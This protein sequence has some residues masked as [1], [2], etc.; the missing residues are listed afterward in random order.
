MYFGM[1]RISA[2]I[3]CI[4]ISTAGCEQKA[5]KDTPEPIKLQ[6]VRV[7]YIPIAECAHLYVG[8]DRGYFRDEGIDIELFP[9]RGGALI[10]PAVAKGDLDIGFSNVVSLVLQNERLRAESPNRLMSLAGASYE[11]PGN[12]NHALLIRTDSSIKVSDLSSVRIAV[13]TTRNIEDLM[14]RRFLIENNIDDS[15]L[16]LVTL[17]FPLMGAALSNGD[18]EVISVV[19]PFIE[20]AIRSGKCTLLARQY[21]E[22]SDETVVATYVSTAKWWDEN[23]K[24]A[25]AFQSAFKRADKFIR[26]NP[27]EFRT[28]L[29]SFTRISPEDL[30]VI[31]LPAFEATLRPEPLDQIIGYMKELD[32]IEASLPAKSMIIVSE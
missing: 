9:M 6:A 5:Q 3:L 14:L 20:P 11:R 21:Q 15:K 23:R 27:V 30:Q 1:K 28:I 26:E 8:V 19:E 25:I 12:T 29:A 24:N 18:V 10:L 4:A 32:F 22:V 31:G 13:N 16:Q 17:G 7:G 2:I